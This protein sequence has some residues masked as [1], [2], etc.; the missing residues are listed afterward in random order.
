[1]RSSQSIPWDGGRVAVPRPILLNFSAPHQADEEVMR[2]EWSVAL[3]GS[4]L[5]G[6]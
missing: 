6:F 4:L 3:S 1:M 5:G 2:H